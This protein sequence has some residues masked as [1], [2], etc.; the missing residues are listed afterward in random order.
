[1]SE[2]D[3]RKEDELRKQ[4]EVDMHNARARSLDLDPRTYQPGRS[5]DDNGAC[6]ASGKN[7]DRDT[8]PLAESCGGTFKAMLQAKMSSRSGKM[9]NETQ[10][11]KEN[12]KA[13]KSQGGNKERTIQD[14]KRKETAHKAPTPEKRRRI[15]DTFSDTYKSDLRSA[16]KRN[17]TATERSMSAKPSMTE[18]R[19]T[20]EK[21]NSNRTH[22][23]TA[24]KSKSRKRHNEKSRGRSKETTDR[25]RSRKRD[26]AR[27]R[28]QRDNE[29]D[30][31]AMA[32]SKSKEMEVP[33]RSRK[34]ERERGSRGE[35]HTSASAKDDDKE[36]NSD[37]D[38]LSSGP[39]TPEL[40]FRDVLG[41]PS[42]LDT[43]GLKRVT[44]QA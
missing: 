20:Q 44:N 6:Q 31:R 23:E 34:P 3:Q 28:S 4:E 11:E 33:R 29:A 21:T 41:N 30:K 1:M 43:I 19:D 17:E 42:V 25:T 5:S 12:G 27:S 2:E 18:A 26:R 32:R 10:S 37:P 24:R 38:N 39:S 14:G 8:A 7:D 13:Q 16:D 40:N 9:N 22:K 35:R 15:P 36:E